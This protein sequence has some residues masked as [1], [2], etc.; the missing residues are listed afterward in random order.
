M[1]ISAVEKYGLRCLLV[2]AR[3]GPEIQLSISEIAE[4]EGLSVPYV[5]KLLSILRREQLVVAARGR[6][7]GFSIARNPK[8]IDLHEVIT[9]LD[10]PLINQ[11]H[12]PDRTGNDSQCIHNDHCSVHDYLGGL[13]G[14]VRHF[15]LATTL[16][17]LISDK[18]FSLAGV[19]SSDLIPSDSL[20]SKGRNRRSGKKKSERTEMNTVGQSQMLKKGID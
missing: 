18:R 14:L 11:E 15:L 1:R 2:L 6:S 13:S 3:S 20:V 10:G 7:G 5:S 19:S 9:A 8:D 4:I 17:D 12:C 16:K